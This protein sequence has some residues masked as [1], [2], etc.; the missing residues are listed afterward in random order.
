[1]APVP[2]PTLALY[3]ELNQDL[4]ALAERTGR[5][6]L[7]LLAWFAGPAV[8][9]AL[10]TWDLAA[11]RADEAQARAD[12]R[13]ALDTLRATIATAPDA[14]ERRRAAAAILRALAPP[15]AQPDSRIH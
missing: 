13:L 3:L 7:E 1:M 11:A 5:S 2:D 14:V 8:Q 15:R 10:A 6:L 4:R 9:E 12:R